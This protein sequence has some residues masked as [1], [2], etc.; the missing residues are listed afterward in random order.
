MMRSS[1]EEKDAEKLQMQLEGLQSMLRLADDRAEEEYKNRRRIQDSLAESQRLLKAAEDDAV[2][3]RDAAAASEE[4]LRTFKE[5][6]L[7]EMERLEKQSALLNENQESLQ[8][9]LSELSQKNI[10]LQGT[11]DEY[12][13]TGDHLRSQ[14]DEVE[15]ENKELRRTISVL[16]TQME[17]SLRARE[18]LRGKF[19]KLQ[20]DMVTTARDISQ[21][22]S[23]WRTKEEQQD[24]RYNVLKAQYDDEVKR[25]KKLEL[26]IDDLE[27][28][29]KEATKLRFIL[30]Q[31]QEENAKLEELLIMV[32][33][34]SH[35]YQNKA[36]KYER[37][38]NEAREI[39]RI[40]IQRVNFVRAELESQINNLDNQLETANMDADTS[41]ARFELL[42]EEARDAKMA[43]LHEAAESK[44]IAL[45][46]Q[47][48]AHERTLND[49]RERHARVLHNGSEDRQREES[50]YMELIALRDERI[51]HLHDKVAHLEEKLEIAKTAAR[52]AA[53]AAQNAKAAQVMSPTQVTS[54]SLTF[55][56]G[57]NV[58]EKISPQALRESILVLQDQLQQREGCIEELEHE[59]SLI[60]K[61]A[62]VKV[63]EKETEIAWLR[64]LL[65]VRLDDLQDI[66][67]VLS[68]P[69]FNQSAVRDAV[70]RL[71]ANLQM[72]Q[73]E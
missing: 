49:L 29:E 10:T 22:Q 41:K 58:P 5:Q 11:L 70:L 24:I 55:T 15:G 8:L 64:E 43:A 56:K 42:L 46:E 32:R 67:N 1:N 4:A 21:E 44:E 68:Q 14:L 62:P 35:D 65:H 34:E 48:L 18:N 37:E 52:T 36:A 30:G 12:R 73:Q 69:S 28:K 2:R 25:R 71:K 3:H 9:T 61:D 39:S 16:K 20:E 66:I 47:R 50:H 54:P 17:D 53:Q 7:P 31:S 27:Q 45:Q 72:Q 23:S 57:T 60:D 26:H 33:Q 13:E 51:D 59:L 38:F 40:E 19:E 63:K 6:K